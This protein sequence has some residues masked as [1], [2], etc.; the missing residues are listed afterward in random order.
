M[1]KE[2]IDMELEAISYLLSQSLT[3]FQQDPSW[4]RPLRLTQPQRTERLNQAYLMVERLRK[5]LAEGKV[6]A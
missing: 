5:D 6:Y 1:N 2:V 3:G 4:I